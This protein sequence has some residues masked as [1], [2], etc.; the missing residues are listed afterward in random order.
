MK[1]AFDV[2]DTLIIPACALDLDRDVPNYDTIAIYLWF[3][4]QGNYMIIWSGG[5]ESY[6][7]MWAD[8]LGLKADEIIAKTT[9]RKEEIDIA[10]DDSEINLAK[11]NIKVRRINNSVSRADFNKHE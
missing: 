10:F 3:Q 4:R 7:K 2:D 6:A 1:I 11:V 5:G 9:Q 8:K